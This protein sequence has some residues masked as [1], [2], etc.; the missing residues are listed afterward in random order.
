[1]FRHQTPLV[2][3]LV[4]GADQ[5]GKTSLVQKFVFDEFLNATPTIGINFAHKLC[6]GEIG[7]LNM[8]IWD[9]SGQPRFRFLAPQ[10]CSGASGVVLVVDQTRPDTLS[11]AVRWL[12]IVSRYAHPLHREAIVLAGT[13]SDLTSKIPQNEIHDFCRTHDI[14]AFIPCSAKTGYNVTKVFTSLSTAIQRLQ[15]KPR[16]PEAP[17]LVTS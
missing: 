4:V 14:F 11:E 12:E 9:L 5:A 7:L 8:S 13:K 17:Y 6:A 2:K 1:M 16:T 3:V 15:L 10:F